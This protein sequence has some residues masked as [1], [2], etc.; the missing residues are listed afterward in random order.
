MQDPR[1]SKRYLHLLLG[2]IVMTCGALEAWFGRTELFGDDISYLDVTHLIRSADWKAAFNPLWSI[3]YPLLLAGIRPIFPAG[4]HGEL[5]AVF[6]LNILICLATWLSF[7]WFLK[8]ATTFIGIDNDEKPSFWCSQN[9]SILVYPTRLSPYTV[10]IAAC[11]FV[12]IE[13]G[14][15]KVSSIGPDQLVVCLFFLASG[16]LLRFLIQPTVKN[17]TRLGTVLG[18][19]FVVKAIFLP[20]SVIV[21]AC[22]LLRF[23]GR[24]PRRAALSISAAFLWF[25]L[26]YAAALSWAI[27]RPTLGESGQLN[28]AYHVNQL[29]H[30]MGWQGGPPRLGT[31][32]HPVHLLRDH[33]A[34]FGFGEPFHVTYPPQ[35]NLHY[36]YDG[37]NHFFSPINAVRSIAVNLHELEK[38]LHENWPFTLALALAFL[39]LATTNWVPHLNRSSIAIQ[40]ERKLWPLYLPS[41]LGIAL[42]LQVHLEGRYIVA[43]I[44]ILAV[45][46][47]LAVESFRP[48]IRASILIILICGTVVDLA[49][50][51]D[52][53]LF[54]AIHPEIVERESRHQWTIAAYL[55]QSGLKPGDRIAAVG[56]GNDIRCTW[57]YAA[58][59]RI[60][61]VIGN[62]AY[63]P[64]KQQE[65]F[66]DFWSKP[67][68]QQD[69]LRLFRE[70]GAVAVVVPAFRPFDDPIDP[71]WQRIPNT[72]AWL[73]RL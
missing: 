38:V 63:D 60:V 71:R 68:I 45:L 70:Q 3:G 40:V 47:F 8:T 23:R 27:G 52:L 9:L 73:L 25:L 7:L 12:V 58:N 51:L 26:P 11:I 15:G 21:I 65:D 16:L 4:I 34:V 56:T 2:I 72:D 5:T 24:L 14:F 31:P 20:L 61:A 35:Y 10:T 30:W 43:F 18:I 46:P 55:N 53:T 67:E 17:G 32:V 36:W 28:Y 62:D 66:L 13:T 59:L 44:A 64:D 1:T 69:V 29:P 41:L 54:R 22:A 50:L 33:P 49:R 48:R 37:Y 39:I 6:A 19:G 57:A 42:Y